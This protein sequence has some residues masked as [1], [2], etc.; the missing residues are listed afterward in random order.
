MSNTYTKF[1]KIISYSF[2][3]MDLTITSY[4]IRKI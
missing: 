2:F 3:L 4:L 1:N